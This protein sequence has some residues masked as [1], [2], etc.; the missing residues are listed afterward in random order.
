MEKRRSG[1]ET[2]QRTKG[3]NLRLLPSEQR[4]LRVLA[5]PSGSSQR[6]GLDSGSLRAPPGTCLA[7][8][9]HTFDVSGRQRGTVV[10]DSA[11]PHRIGQISSTLASIGDAKRAGDVADVVAQ[12][13]S[14]LCGRSGRSK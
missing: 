11:L 10:D 6:S 5:R 12:K 14:D 2:R 8:I 3:L 9:G 1:S 7:L 13:G 4:A